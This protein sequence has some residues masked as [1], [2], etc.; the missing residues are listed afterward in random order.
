[1]SQQRQAPHNGY[2][3]ELNKT[4]VADTFT[5]RNRLTGEIA[6]FIPREFGP[7]VLANERWG[8]AEPMEFPNA[9]DAYETLHLQDRWTPGFKTQDY[10]IV[11]IRREVT[12]SVVA[13]TERI[14]V[15]SLQERIAMGKV[16]QLYG[17]TDEDVVDRPEL[18]LMLVNETAEQNLAFFQASINKAVFAKG[19][20]PSSAKRLLAACVP[21]EEYPYKDLEGTLLLVLEG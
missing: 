20:P 11:R 5:L 10:D 12:L 2:P 4:Q 19:A 9:Q 6:R 21:P 7:L 16:A 15:D 13:P 1:M 18:T 14:R 3:S 8:K 17:L